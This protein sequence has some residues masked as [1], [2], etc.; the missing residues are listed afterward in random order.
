MSDQPADAFSILRELGFNPT[1]QGLD[2]AVAGLAKRL[3]NHERALA[4][5]RA[6][7]AEAENRGAV[8]ALRAMANEMAEIGQT[9][10]AVRLQGHADNIQAGEVTP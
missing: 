2:R 7:L 1:T 4:E 3:A 9:G 10:W 5:T 8:K 6:M